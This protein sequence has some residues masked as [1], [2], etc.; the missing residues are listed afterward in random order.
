MRQG[1]LVRVHRGFR[2]YYNGG[3]MVEFPVGA[4]AVI[5]SRFFTG[6]REYYDILV[7][8]GIWAVTPGVIEPADGTPLYGDGGDR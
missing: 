6:G 3:R 8:G 1:D 5:V 4:I 2:G 7:D